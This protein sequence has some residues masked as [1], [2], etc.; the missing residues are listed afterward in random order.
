MFLDLSGENEKFK[1]VYQLS[2]FL[3]EQPDY[4]RRA[5]ALTLDPN[6]PHAGLK[7][8]HG[9]YGSEDWWN[10]IRTGDIGNSTEIGSI[11]KIYA[12][13]PPSERRPKTEMEIQFED[14][15]RGTWTMRANDR[16]DLDLFRLGGRV[17]MFIIFDELKKPQGERKASDIVIE[18][19]VSQPGDVKSGT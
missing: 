17:M 10:N 12:V 19:A 4:I 8:T 7:G 5:Q 16:R 13:G 9:L 2:V 11:S 6:M 3:Q 18:M 15:R 14:G 1:L